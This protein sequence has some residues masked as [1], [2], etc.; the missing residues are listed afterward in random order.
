MNGQNYC[1][2]LFFGRGQT[3]LADKLADGES[4]KLGRNIPIDLVLTDIRIPGSMNGFGLAK[5]V[6]SNKPAVGVIFASGEANRQKPQKNFVITFRCS[7]SL[8]T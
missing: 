6:S 5:R 2:N 1:N 8:T 3:A 7:K 4:Y